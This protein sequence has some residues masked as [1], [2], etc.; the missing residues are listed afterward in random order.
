[1]LAELREECTSAQD[2]CVRVNP[3]PKLNSMEVR[4]SGRNIEVYN[5]KNFDLSQTLDCGQC[6]RWENLNG[7]YQGIAFGKIVTVYQ[8]DT[9]I[10]FENVN[11][12][13]FKNIWI[14][15]FD[16]NA[17]YEKISE[18]FLGINS[19]MDSA[20]K[21]CAGIRILRQEP[22]EAL[23][24]FIISQNNNIPRIKKIINSLCANFGDDIGGKYSFPRPQK[25]ANLSVE[26]LVPIRAGFRAKYIIDA[27]Q[28]VCSG[29]VD[30]E[31]MK[32]MSDEEAKNV[33]MKIRGVG[34]K[35]ADCVMLY[36]M[37]RLSAFPMDVW[38]KR[39]M[40]RFFPGKNPDFF[41]LYAGIAQQ[42]LYHYSRGNPS[43]FGN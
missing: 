6:F 1:M 15:Y 5:P 12:N 31:S 42:Y 20:V 29:A 28:K 36:G 19:V 9:K 30:F 25:L 38:M 43:I 17:D 21:E 16:L 7:K 37:H 11:V 18:K 41:G 4:Q 3:A 8:E 13:D 33:L 40:D 14:N 34:P 23:C 22:W 39:V 35:V 2:V 24:S 10:V 26:N 27:A 32:K